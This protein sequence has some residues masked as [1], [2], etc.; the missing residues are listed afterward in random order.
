L[1]PLSVSAIIQARMTSSRLPGKILLEVDG[2]P[3]LDYLIERL[4]NTKGVSQI[5]V[6]T[7]SNQE[8]DPVENYCIT[9]EIKF[10]RGDEQ[11]VLGRIYEASI[12]YHADPI[13]R[14]TADCPLIDPYIL[15]SQIKFFSENL[16]DYCYLGLTYPEGVCSDLF[17]FNA[18][19]KAY[20][21]SVS[22]EDREHVTPYFH[23]N[24]N[25]FRIKS[26]ENKEDLSRHRFVKIFFNNLRW[27]LQ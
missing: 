26:L 21:N 24:K 6:A 22:T 17:H 2:R 15:D 9:N 8:D 3:L 1:N 4:K 16:I 18:L 5:I 11:D 12:S 20:Q 13:M 25:D 19:E 7:T 10:Y 14:I 23:K 27:L